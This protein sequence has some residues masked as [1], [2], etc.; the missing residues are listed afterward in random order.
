MKNKMVS[1][2]IKYSQ[3]YH[4]NISK[5]RK[6]NSTAH[7]FIEQKAESMRNQGIP[8]LSTQMI[9]FKLFDSFSQN[10]RT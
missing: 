10:D 8:D 2:N 5:N 3:M 7:S 4:S 9:A 6:L 1:D